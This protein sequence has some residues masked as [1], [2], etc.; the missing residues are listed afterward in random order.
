MKNVVE[1]KP[2]IFKWIINEF[3]QSIIGSKYSDL[4]NDWLNDRKKPT[5]NQIDQLSK[6]LH[7]PFGYFFLEQEPK[8]EIKLLEF[9]TIYNDKYSKPSRDL[10]DT[11]F[12][13]EDIQTWMSEYKK[14]MGYESLKFVGN[15]KDSLNE[16]EP[17]VKSIRETLEL[18]ERWFEDV[19]SRSDAY[20]LLKTKIEDKGILIMS[21]G[22][23]G[24]N[25]HRSLNIDEFRAFVIVDNFAP[26]VFINDTDTQNA[27]IFSLIHEIAHVW[28]GRS[29]LFNSTYEDNSNIN[30]VEKKCNEIAAEIIVPT[31][32]F[33]ELWNRTKDNV[34]EKIC[35]LSEHFKCSE[36]V[37]ARRALDYKYINKIIYE[38]VQ[39]KAIK[40]YRTS[41]KKNKGF[42][43]NFYNTQNSRYDK[44]F[45]GAVYHSV[46]SGRI[47]Y[48]DAYR[49]TKTNGKTFGK[50]VEERALKNE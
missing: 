32:V 47:T 6:K 19:R 2:E 39:I 1:I 45:I 31:H 21:N 15:F 30:I 26:L 8:E 28:I 49:L 36:T 16:I 34:Y 11:I 40:E 33:K 10:I 38:E 25:T 7:I 5:Y 35:I 41:R 4:I 14:E 48:T 3:D 24:N 18:K 12:Y 44:N 23:V 22:V 43:G 9:R 46:N 50:V 42:G 20:K 29:N 13:M 27:K 37:I 17:I